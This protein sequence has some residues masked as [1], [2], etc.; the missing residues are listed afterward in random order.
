MG[1]VKSQEHMCARDTLLA[2]DGMCCGV[3]ACVVVLHNV[4]GLALMCVCLCVCVC[5]PVRVCLCVCGM[6]SLLGLTCVCVSV[7]TAHSLRGLTR[8]CV[9][10]CTCV[11]FYVC[12]WGGEGVLTV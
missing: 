8:V 5:V 2:A 12:M 9:Y 6:R 4:M 7:N 1:G 3:A 11:C 10:V